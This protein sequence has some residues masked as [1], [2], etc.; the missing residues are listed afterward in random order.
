MCVWSALRERLSCWWRSVLII[1]V[2]SRC[3]EFMTNAS[4]R[5][6]LMRTPASVPLWFGGPPERVSSFEKFCNFAVGC[7]RVVVSSCLLV[8]ED[9]ALSTRCLYTIWGSG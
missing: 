3:A 6:V 5:G 9:N 8:H 2:H 4:R 7:S 1:V